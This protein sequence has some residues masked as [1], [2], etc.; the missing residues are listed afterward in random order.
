M[1]AFS[2]SARGA[3]D[4]WERPLSAVNINRLHPMEDDEPLIYLGFPLIQG[5]I[6]RVHCVA[7]LVTKIKIATQIHSTR[8]LSVVDKATVLNSLLLQNCDMLRG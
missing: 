3:W 7:S 8:S 5:K 6:Q 4:I 2:A 1:E